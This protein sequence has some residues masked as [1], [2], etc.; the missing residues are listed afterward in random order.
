MKAD[1]EIGDEIQVRRSDPVYNAHSYLT[2]VPVTAIV[3]FIRRYSEPGDVVL[4][5]FA[6]SGMTGVA[7]AMSGRRAI[8]VDISELGRHIGTNYLNFVDHSVLTDVA[9]R[10]LKR[11]DEMIGHP[12]TL[13]CRRC[14]GTAVLSRSI[15]SFVYECDECSAPIVF[16]E[17]LQSD[18]GQSDAPACARCAA[19]LRKRTARRIGEQR[20]RDV[21]ACACSGTLIEQEPDALRDDF[22]IP[23]TLTYPDVM[24]EPHRE[25]FRR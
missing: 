23:E 13:T 8:L 9:E 6:G 7:A 19:P 25:M 20:V 4:D 3:P 14:E 18:G 17:A 22:A 2:K 12:Y 5:F 11:A 1:P 15:W 24:I 21:T 10:A 16:F